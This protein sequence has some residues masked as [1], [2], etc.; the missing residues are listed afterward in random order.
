MKLQSATR[1]TIEPEDL[2]TEITK[3][4]R[5]T[6]HFEDQFNW[7]HTYVN[8]YESLKDATWSTNEIRSRVKHS[9]VE[10]DETL[11][12]IFFKLTPAVLVSL[13]VSSLRDIWNEE[14]FL[15]HRATH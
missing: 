6:D 7:L 2:F 14:L 1:K 15:Y 9:F 12:A 5:C 13:V 3:L 11:Q 8:N 10:P 4:C